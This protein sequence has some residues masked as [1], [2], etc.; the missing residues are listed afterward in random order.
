MRCRPCR[1]RSS[2]C[3]SPRI[4]ATMP[5]RGRPPSCCC[6]SFS[7]RVSVRAGSPHGAVVRSRRRADDEGGRHVL[8]RHRREGGDPAEA[9]A[10]ARAARARV[11]R[12][13]PRR[14]LRR[15]AGR[16]GRVDGHLQEPRHRDHRSVGLRQE[17]VHPL[18]QP[19]E[20][21]DS[22]LLDER[23][24]PLPGPG[25]L[26]LGRRSG[27]GAPVRRDGVP[28]AEPVPEVDPGQRRVGHKGARDEGPHGRAHR[29]G[30][31]AGGL[32]GR[33]EGPAEGE[34]PVALRRPAA[35]PLHRARHRG[36]AGRRADGRARVGARPD[37]DAGD[38]AADARPE[39]SVLVRD[40]HAQHAAGGARRRHDRL[41]LDLARRRGR[42]IRRARRIRRDRE[43]LHGSV[44]QADGGLRHRPLRLARKAEVAG[45]PSLRGRSDPRKAGRSDPLQVVP[46]TCP[47]VSAE[48]ERRPLAA[49]ESPG[50]TWVYTLAAIL[51][52]TSIVLAV[53]GVGEVSG[54]LT[55]WQ[56]FTL[57]IVQGF[58]ELLPISSS[59]HLILVPW[60]ANWHYL[61]NHETFNKTF[62]VSLHLGTLVAVVVYFWHDIVRIVRAWLHTLRTRR[63]ATADERVAWYVLAA[64]IPAGL[65][66]ALGEEV[67]EKHLGEPWQIAIFLAF[68]GILLWIADR[69]P[70]RREIDDLR[71]RTAFLIGISQIL[72]LMPGV[73][74]SGITITTGR[75]AGLSRDA[76]AR[77]SFLLLIPVVAGAVLYAG[78]KHVLLNPLPDGWVGPFL[79]GTIAA[80]GAGLLA[81]DALLG[82]VRRH[83]YS[84]FVIYRLALAAFILIIIA[85]GVRDATF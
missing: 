53:L 15:Q 70:E 66:G 79:V 8:D 9:S 42:A 29:A 1:S 61:E 74:R 60:L 82:Y 30:S 45:Q 39:G 4:R 7:L 84:I 64:T 81:I 40:R 67:F 11:Q 24:D 83:D 71:F 34:R 10:A 43:D 75:F 20:R 68:F 78:T 31:H 36:P 50:R 47:A 5:A 37:R 6:S 57:G 51:L 38:R 54:R 80:A 58:T 13:E 44:R 85:T 48:A 59:G 76:A 56:A 21:P 33:G 46:L 25:H 26:R 77:F 55:D 2:S 28:A 14:A 32:V 62:D 23:D 27:R 52:V 12:R 73:S 35:A 17:H 49:A 72:A 69:R 22:E 41:L 16:E 63:A 65:A 19:D 18:L 3:R